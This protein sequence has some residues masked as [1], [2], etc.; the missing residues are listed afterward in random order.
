MGKNNTVTF[1]KIKF[2]TER[3]IDRFTIKSLNI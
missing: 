3:L 2:E 1:K